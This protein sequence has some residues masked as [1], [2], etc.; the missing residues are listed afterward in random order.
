MYIFKMQYNY[1][2]IFLVLIHGDVY[3]NIFDEC[4]FDQPFFS[5]QAKNIFIGKSIVCPMT[6]FSGAEDKE[7]FDG[8]T[9]LI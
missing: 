2:N 5:F 3:V 4:K 6:E 7:G 9:L 1:C 8:N